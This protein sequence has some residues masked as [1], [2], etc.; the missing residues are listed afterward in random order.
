MSGNHI[1]SSGSSSPGESSGFAPMAGASVVAAAS[2]PGRGIVAGVPSPRRGAAVVVGASGTSAPPHRA[3]HALSVANR[4]MAEL[5][6]C[7]SGYELSFWQVMLVPSTT[8]YH[9]S[10]KL[11]GQGWSL[12][13]LS[14]S[15]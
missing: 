15:S 9:L 1:I 8:G 13:Q 6:R 5:A 10:A 2:S 11:V 7:S 3:R 14:R 4:Y 12:Q